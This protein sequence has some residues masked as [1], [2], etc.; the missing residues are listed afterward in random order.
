MYAFWYYYFGGSASGNFTFMKLK[1][2]KVDSLQPEQ[3]KRLLSYVIYG[4]WVHIRVYP[5]IFLPIILAHEYHVYGKSK[6]GL[7][8]Q[9]IQIGLIGGGVFVLLALI[10]YLKYGYSFLENTY[11]YHLTRKDNR[12]SFS[13]YFY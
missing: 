5:I 13:P 12:H 1:N 8:K 2:E 3:W 9:I 10:F 4:L 11:L 7:I 6:S